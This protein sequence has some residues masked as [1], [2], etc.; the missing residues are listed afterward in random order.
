MA[1]Q[2]ACRDLGMDCDYVASGATMDELMADGG[3]H[4][5]E[6]HGFTDEQMQDPG[7]AEKLKAAIK[8][9]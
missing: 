9:T 4:G 6:V 5:K 8:Q 7:L 3:K 2:I 1:F